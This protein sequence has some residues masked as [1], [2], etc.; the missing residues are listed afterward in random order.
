MVQLGDKCGTGVRA[1]IS[2]PTPFMYLRSV[3]VPQNLL[4]LMVLLFHLDAKNV[5]KVKKV[6]KISFAL[7]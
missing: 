4:A 7:P 2:K 3:K 5:G 6:L 1:S